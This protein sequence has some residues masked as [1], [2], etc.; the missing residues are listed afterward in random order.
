[1]NP[2]SSMTQEKP[3]ES[4]LITDQILY[5]YG[6]FTAEN[7]KLFQNF[8]TQLTKIINKLYCMLENVETV[9][10][11]LFRRN[12]MERKSMKRFLLFWIMSLCI[13]EKWSQFFLKWIM[14]TKKMKNDYESKIIMNS[15]LFYAIIAFYD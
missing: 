14:K 12:R 10:I 11:H 5:I 9:T 3:D 2:E 7:D 1:M 13:R 6:T 8:S 4:D 15:R